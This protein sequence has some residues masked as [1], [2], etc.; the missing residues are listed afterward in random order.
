M[1]ADHL[2]YRLLMRLRETCYA[3][4]WIKNKV[5]V[6]SQVEDVTVVC[7]QANQGRKSL[8]SIILRQEFLV[9]THSLCCEVYYDGKLPCRLL[10]VVSTSDASSH[11]HLL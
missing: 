1:S 10:V 4:D 6:C 3:V 2:R 8:L 9:L 7:K 5:E 11:L